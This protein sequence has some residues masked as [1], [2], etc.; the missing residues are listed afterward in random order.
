[1]FINR[2]TVSSIAVFGLCQNLFN[3]P[4]NILKKHILG[5]LKKAGFDG[6]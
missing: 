4:I 6:M 5:Y 2:K 3:H 1:M